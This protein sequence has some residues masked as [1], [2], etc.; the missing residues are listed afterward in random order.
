MTPAITSERRLAP[1][2]SAHRMVRHCASC[3][4]LY[5]NRT[6]C[7]SCGCERWTPPLPPV[8]QPPR[9]Q[10]TLCADCCIRASCPPTADLYR[11]NDGSETCLEFVPNTGGQRRASSPVRCPELMGAVS[12]ASRL[13]DE[14]NNSD[15]GSAAE[16][17]RKHPN[18][19]L[20]DETGQDH[21]KRDGKP[22]HKK[23]CEQSSDSTNQSANLA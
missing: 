2:C 18:N 8:P 16:D 1:S 23:I 13:Y 14:S 19:K 4:V 9:G 7:P 11:Y 15:D 22:D 3:G 20:P 10:G 12:P 5:W 21:H 17:I 6:S